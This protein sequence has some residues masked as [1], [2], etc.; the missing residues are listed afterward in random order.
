[1][2]RRRYLGLHSQL[3]TLTISGI[4]V[5]RIFHPGDIVPHCHV[6]HFPLLI[7]S[8]AFSDVEFSCPAFSVSPVRAYCNDA[9]TVLAGVTFCHLANF[10][11][12]L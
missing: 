10:I 11:A 12:A 7:N 2:K 9:S 3:S 4:F 5:S 6:L 8:A 1:V